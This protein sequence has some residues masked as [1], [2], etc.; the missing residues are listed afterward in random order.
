MSWWR[1]DREVDAVEQIEQIEGERGRSSVGSQSRPLAAGV[2]AMVVIAMVIVLAAGAW[3]TWRAFVKHREVE[4][5]AKP[6]PVSGR[7]IPNLVVSMIEHSDMKATTQPAQEPRREPPSAS[8]PR[9]EPPGRSSVPPEKTSDEKLL[10]Q[11][12]SSKGFGEN[13]GGAQESQPS[14]SVAGGRSSGG[15]EF[16]E[17]LRSNR[18]ATARARMLGDMDMTIT[19]GSTV[20]C[21]LYTVLVTTQPGK[22][23]CY[24][25]EDWWSTSGNV[26]L[27]PKGSKITGLSQGGISQGQARVFATFGLI[28]GSDGV[29]IEFDAPAAGALGEPGIGG[30][31]DNHTLQRFGGAVMIGMIDLAGQ[32]AVAATRGGGGGGNQI[33]FGGT[34]GGMQSAAAEAL[35]NTINIMPTLS[36]QPGQIIQIVAA[37]KMFFGDVYTLRSR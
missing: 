37:Q 19:E 24:T 9:Q 15:G 35:K 30:D 34:V 1:R 21:Q 17:K 26:K 4:Q 33:Q 23:V 31:V 8:P 32:A 36:T 3:A 7:V 20:T 29:E 10:D 2:K 12:L 13:V 14:V 6:V 11:R 5:A 27:V 22:A 25:K 16:A 18:M 28:E